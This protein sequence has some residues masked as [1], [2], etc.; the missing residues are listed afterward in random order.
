VMAILSSP[1]QRAYML[2]A[3]LPTPT[4]R[5]NIRLGVPERNELRPAGQTAGIQSGEN[6]QHHIESQNLRLFKGCRTGRRSLQCGHVET[7]NSAIA[8]RSSAEAM[9]EDD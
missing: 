6:T 4:P 7:L 2:F 9:A 1:K 3:G 5:S 8:S